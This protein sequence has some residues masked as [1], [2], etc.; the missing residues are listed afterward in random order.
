MPISESVKPLMNYLAS[1][2]F[3]NHSGKR[4]GR[5]AT[6]LSTSFRIAFHC[7]ANKSSFRIWYADQLKGKAS[8]FEIDGLAGVGVGYLVED[9][10]WDSVLSEC[11]FCF[12][13]T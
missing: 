2:Q 6:L 13:E 5:T 7:A 11:R 8:G 1:S 3:L 10:G 4:R 9:K 12:A